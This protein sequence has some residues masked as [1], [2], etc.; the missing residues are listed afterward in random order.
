MAVG[1]GRHGCRLCVHLSQVY[2]VG[3][4]ADPTYALHREPNP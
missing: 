3:T 2:P 1:F 4:V